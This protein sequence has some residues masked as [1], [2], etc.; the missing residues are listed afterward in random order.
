MLFSTYGFEGAEPDVRASGAICA[1]FLS[2]P[3][4]RIALLCGLGAG[5]DRAELAEVLASW[6]AA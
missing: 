6:D 5:A 1:P 4:A 3:A 2:P